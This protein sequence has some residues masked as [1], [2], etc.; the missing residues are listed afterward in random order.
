MHTPL[1]STL[2]YL[3]AEVV[4]DEPEDVEAE[5]GEEED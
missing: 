4:D 3:D 2:R 5:A 1:S